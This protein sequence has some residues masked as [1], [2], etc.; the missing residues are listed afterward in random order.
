MVNLPNKHHPRQ[1]LR[2]ESSPEME[3]EGLREDGPP[4]STCQVREGRE[5]LEKKDQGQAFFPP[6]FRAAE[7]EIKTH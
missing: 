3:E 4:P 1:K 7:R 5:R 6:Q 2:P